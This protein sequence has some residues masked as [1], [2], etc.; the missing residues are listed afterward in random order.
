MRSK[1]IK[2]K[3]KNCSLLVAQLYN[4]RTFPKA[5]TTHKRSVKQLIIELSFLF[6]PTPEYG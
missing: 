6:G 5:S 3:T 4:D 1:A 2:L